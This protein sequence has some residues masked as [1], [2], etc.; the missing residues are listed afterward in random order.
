MA[1]YQC[2]SIVSNV[3]DPVLPRWAFFVR[4]FCALLEITYRFDSHR[5]DCLLDNRRS[6]AIVC[7]FKWLSSGAV[8]L[9][10]NRR[11][12]ADSCWRKLRGGNWPLDSKRIQKRREVKASLIIPWLSGEHQPDSE[13]VG[14][15]EK[16]RKWFHLRC[17]FVQVVTERTAST[18]CMGSG[19]PGCLF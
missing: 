10:C 3:A 5:W 1:R 15:G 6:E 19:S 17:P 4:E 9:D 12:F 2:D 7:R 14:K 8:F 18:G 16:H 13:C 11:N